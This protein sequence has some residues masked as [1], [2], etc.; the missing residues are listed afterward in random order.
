MLYPKT[1]KKC[2][3][4]IDKWPFLHILYIFDWIQHNCFAHRVFALDLS[5]NVIK[6]L[7]G[8]LGVA[9]VSDILRHRG[10]QLILASSWARPA[11]LVA[12]KGWGGMFLFLLGLHFHSC[13]SFFPVPLF[14]LLYYVFC[15]FFPFSGR[16]PKMTHKGWC[17]IKPQLY[18][19]TR[20]RLWC[21][22]SF[23]NYFRGNWLWQEYF[24][25]CSSGRR[26]FT[27]FVA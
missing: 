17:D 27:N 13:S 20:K 15:L 1:K 6:R 14:H 7:W 25:Q 10:I 9:K 3:E 23:L 21:T 16:W 19:I 5:N 24:Y 2:I 8:W 11:I 18:S 22:L 12:G 26:H 4:Y